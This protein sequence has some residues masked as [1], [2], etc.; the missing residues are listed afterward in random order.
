MST[1]VSLSIELVCLLNWLVRHEKAM[2]NNLLKH[3]LERGF[4]DELD[5]IDVTLL[6]GD[7]EELQNTVLDFL[8]YLEYLLAR[9]LEAVHVD[10]TT[11]NAIMPTLQRLAIDNLDDRTLQASMRHTKAQVLRPENQQTIDGLAQTMAPAQA[12]QAQSQHINKILFE[13]LLK[14]WKPNN[15][16]TM[17]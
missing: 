10:H 1:Q 2:L 15:K 7:N 4:A 14:N 8:D 16:E 11:R 12:R 6:G 17:N 13:Q 3:A 9:N 5:K